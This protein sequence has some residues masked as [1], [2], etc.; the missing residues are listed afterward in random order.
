MEFRQAVQELWQILCRAQSCPSRA[1]SSHWPVLVQFLILWNINECPKA[2]CISS[3]RCKKPW[4]N[5]CH[6]YQV[7][8]ERKLCPEFQCLSTSCEPIH[9]GCIGYQKIGIKNLYTTQKT[10]SESG[11]LL[12][13]YSRNKVGQWANMGQRAQVCLSNNV[14]MRAAINSGFFASS[15]DYQ[16]GLWTIKTTW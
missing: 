5:T 2:V 13:S 7:I 8:E 1:L 9:L 6:G 11:H 15:R 14:I 3:T 12:W 16:Y 10:L 4:V